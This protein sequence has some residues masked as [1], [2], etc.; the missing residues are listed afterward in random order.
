[1]DRDVD[2]LLEQ[3]RRRSHRRGEMLSVVA[4]VLIHGAVVVAA[5]VLPALGD[6]PP[7]PPRIARVQVVPLQA[8]GSR[9]VPAE[10]EPP[11]DPR[12][13]TPTPPPEPEPK[14]P[15]PEARTPPE[16]TP[17]PPEP[18]PE[19]EPAGQPPPAP[20]TEA[21]PA[22][23]PRDR[24]GSPE[25][26]PLGTSSIGVEAGIENPDFRYDYYLER[27]LSLIEA[28]WRRPSTEDRLETLVH[29]RIASDGRVTDLHVARSSES[30]AFDLSALRAVQ[31]ASPLPPL[32]R[33]YRK[34]SLGVNLI[35]R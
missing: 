4:A 3:R 27:M 25:G 22:S 31:Q 1:M 20:G 8:L 17:A 35:F 26:S 30:R 10:P 16:E 11:P 13:A 9:N 29:F 19:R 7:E 6:E 5:L 23:P 14:P 34:D 15:K 28:Q 24:R 12:R 33:S 18:T 2:E 32:P 21:A